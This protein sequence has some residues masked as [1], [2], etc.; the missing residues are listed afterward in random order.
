M[1]I[2]GPRGD[3]GGFI[4]S[5]LQRGEHFRNPELARLARIADR[6]FAAQRGHGSP[7]LIDP[8]IDELEALQEHEGTYFALIA[9]MKLS[10]LFPPEGVALIG[11]IA[12]AA[13][14]GRIYREHH[15]VD[16]AGSREF[17]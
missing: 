16:A 4:D 9:A 17:F 7:V 2:E 8:P 13:H 15:D 10:Q 14:V 3:L 1:G 6:V 5:L 12:A 11:G